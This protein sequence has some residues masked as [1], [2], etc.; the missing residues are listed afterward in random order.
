MEPQ[1]SVGMIHHR[2]TGTPVSRK[3]II[4]VHIKHQGGRSGENQ[5]TRGGA[6]P[7]SKS[8]SIDRSQNLDLEDTSISSSFPLHTLQGKN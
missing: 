1:E 7:Q 4:S 3:G 8:I 2:K 5:L 6:F